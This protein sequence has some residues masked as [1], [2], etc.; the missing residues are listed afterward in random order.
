MIEAIMYAAFAFF[1]LSIAWLLWGKW[2][3]DNRLYDASTL[4]TL[5]ALGC[6]LMAVMLMLFDIIAY[7]FSQLLVML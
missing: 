1:L 6:F 2:A 5:V 7:G 3:R 4:M